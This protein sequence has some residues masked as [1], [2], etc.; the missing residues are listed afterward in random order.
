M[1]CAR[2]TGSLRALHRA[3]HFHV[4]RTYSTVMNPLAELKRRSMIV[5][6]TGEVPNEH[7]VAYV[8]FDP[9]ADALH[10]GSLVQLNAM[11]L[12][13]HAGHDVVALIGTATALVGDPTGRSTERP[14]L[15]PDQLVENAAGIEECIRRIVPSAVVVRNGDWW[16]N[17]GAVEFLRDV[18]RHFRVGKMLGQE[19]VRRRLEND[20]LSFTEF[21]YSL[22]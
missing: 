2:R 5:S 19:S 4:G 22:M 7:T 10:I 12:L 11:R 6:C 18:G 1:W 14:V 8:G 9:T 15:S 3:L 17:F 16:S 13:A 20:G 21:S